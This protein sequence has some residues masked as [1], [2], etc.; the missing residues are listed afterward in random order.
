MGELCFRRGH[1]WPEPTD[2]ATRCS[3]PDHVPIH[4]KTPNRVI[5]AIIGIAKM[6][7]V[8]SVEPMQPIAITPEPNVAVPIASDAVNTPVKPFCLAE[9]GEGATVKTGKAVNAV[10]MSDPKRSL[11]VLVDRID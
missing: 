7:E 11:A 6:G 1:C 2:S 10:S 4:Q 9:P 3:K 8:R 5:R